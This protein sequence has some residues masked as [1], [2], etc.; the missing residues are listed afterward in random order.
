M[1]Y[2]NFC[3]HVSSFIIVRVLCSVLIHVVYVCCI[4]IAIDVG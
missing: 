3:I 2:L 1:T 4:E